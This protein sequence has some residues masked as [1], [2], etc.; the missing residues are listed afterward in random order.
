MLPANRT[1]RR[2]TAPG[3]QEMILKRADLKQAACIRMP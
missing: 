1:V 2:E 3:E